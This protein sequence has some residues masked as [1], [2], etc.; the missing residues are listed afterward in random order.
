[1]LLKISL[2]LLNRTQ[3]FNL[4]QY[5]LPLVCESSSHRAPHHLN[6]LSLPVVRMD[7]AG[8][9]R[10]LFLLLFVCLFVCLFVRNL[11]CLFAN[12]HLTLRP[13]ISMSSL[14]LL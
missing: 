12:H 8:S 2:N 3:P 11:V 13:T 10:D 9:G 4:T 5:G 6:V 14:W 7:R 1:M